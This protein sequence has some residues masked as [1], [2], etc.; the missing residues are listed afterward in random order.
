MAGMPV[1]A[2]TF[3]ACVRSSSS[4]SGGVIEWRF[5]ATYRAITAFKPS[6]SSQLCGIFSWGLRP[7]WTGTA[8]GSSM[9]ISRLSGMIFLC[10]RPESEEPVLLRKT[11]GPMILRHLAPR[12]ML[13]MPRL[14]GFHFHQ[15]RAALRGIAGGV[16]R[17]QFAHQ[18]GTLQHHTAPRRLGGG[19]AEV[20]QKVGLGHDLEDALLVVNRLARELNDRAR[21]DVAVRADMVAD[22]GRHGAERFAI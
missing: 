12:L 5:A 13:A 15:R 8:R 9:G 19:L 21:F 6:R 17:H 3:S 11:I 10:V 7:A 4:T 2:I 1:R 14:H 16:A 22:A 18:V 20:A